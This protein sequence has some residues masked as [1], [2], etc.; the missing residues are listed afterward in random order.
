MTTQPDGTYEM[1]ITADSIQ[2]NEPDT[3][4]Y[5]D[6]SFFANM[7]SA[8]TPED[9]KFKPADGEPIKRNRNKGERRISCQTLPRL[10]CQVFEDK[11]LELP[12]DKRE[13]FPICR[14]GLDKPLI[15]GIFPDE[16]RFR[17][18]C[19]N[20]IEYVR[21]WRG[22][23]VQMYL[24][25]WNIFS[26]LFFV[27]E[28]LKRFGKPND[29]FILRYRRKTSQE[30]SNAD[31]SVEEEKGYASPDDEK[32]PVYN[33]KYSQTLLDSKN[34]IFRG[35]PGTGKTYLARQ[36]AADIV[37]DGK[38]GDW[39]KLDDEQRRRIGFVQFHPSYDYTDFVEGI[40][41]DTEETDA[42]GTHGF[43]IQDGIFKR[44]LDKA[45]DNVEQSRLSK[46]ERREPSVRERLDAYFDSLDFDD[47][48]FRI[49][50]GKPFQVTN[51]TEHHV[52][53]YAPH[54][55]KQ[56][57]RIRVQDLLALMQSST[58]PTNGED[59][60]H[61]LERKRR[62][63]E[64]SY[65]F[66][67]LQ[68]IQKHKPSSASR[69]S[70]KVLRKPFVF[71]ID[72]INRG[73]I[74]KIFGELFFSI[75]PGYRGPAGNVTTQYGHE[76]YVPDNV[77]IIGTMNDIDRSVD[78]FDFAM[79]RRFRFIEVKA[80]DGLDMLEELGGLS[81]EAES[82]LT[83]LNETISSPDIGLGSDY[84]VGPAYFLN[85]SK[86]E[87]TAK[88]FDDLWRDFLQPLLH[89]Y[90]R[91]MYNETEIME[92]LKAAYEDASDSPQPAERSV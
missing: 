7:G 12:Y 19:K 50:T 5:T 62:Q 69:A 89:D 52:L 24:Y 56:E 49:S 67:L 1:I 55:I 41:P 87:S 80:E 75:D 10:T 77:Y 15:T 72:E 86:S 61:I 9:V 91:G 81:E 36:I 57:L 68:E 33:N 78:T 37:S 92:K 53:V 26:T 45:R 35:A 64:D 2:S 51:V 48:Q 73:E 44:F 38:R 8:Y 82:R 59:V 84:H 6:P 32:P 79:R 11:L 60:H 14:Y 71:I 30:A 46:E 23:D 28:C 31:A 54:G 90:V 58:P 83:K 29:A 21:Y 47:N 70:E 17:S 40:R 42:T 4:S 74:S 13:S 65:A 25:C 63:R 34:I 3:D 76:L 16:E 43:S 85:L 39:S 22:T 66:A 18:G 27:Q 88:A 20:S